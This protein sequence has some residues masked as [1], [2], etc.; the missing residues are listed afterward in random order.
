M[1]GNWCPRSNHRSREYR[2]SILVEREMVAHPRS[3][4]TVTRTIATARLQLQRVDIRWRIR[5]TQVSDARNNDKD[6]GSN[7]WKMWDKLKPC[8]P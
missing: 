5:L 2:R 8:D 1:L 7:W 3:A 4:I 6:D